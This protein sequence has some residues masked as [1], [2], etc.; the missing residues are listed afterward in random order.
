MSILS[1]R[2][3]WRTP[4]LQLGDAAARWAVAPVVILSV[5]LLAAGN[6]GF[7]APAWGWSAAALL[8]AGGLVMIVGEPARLRTVEW[9]ALA[10]FAALAAW[11]AVSQLWEGAATQPIQ[12]AER[13]LVYVAGIFA[14]MLLTKR[15]ALRPV[16]TGLLIAILAA[17]LY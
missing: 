14:C 15:G 13:T 11:M 16:L 5:G 10:A 3:T 12:E 17:A 8:W 4:G 9:T 6:G 2:T 1:D 7:F